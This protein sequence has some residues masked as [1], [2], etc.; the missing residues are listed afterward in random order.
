MVVPTHLQLS[1]SNSILKKTT[2]K[3]K[4]YFINKSDSQNEHTKLSCG[5]K[6]LKNI[7]LKTR[8]VCDG[9]LIVDKIR[10]LKLNFPHAL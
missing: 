7:D 5:V 10:M 6:I 8:K 2:K 9:E 4:I 3:H 1:E